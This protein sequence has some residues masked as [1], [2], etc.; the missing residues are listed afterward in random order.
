MLDEQVDDALVARVQRVVA[1][2][3]PAPVDRV[4]RR[5]CVVVGRRV[6]G[7]REVLEL[8]PIDRVRLDRTQIRV[9]EAV[10]LLDPLD[11]LDRVDRLDR[12]RGRLPIIF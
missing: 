1:G 9:L 12:L 2:A 3:L 7:A 5:A 6:A 4:P 10:G 8:P 11:R